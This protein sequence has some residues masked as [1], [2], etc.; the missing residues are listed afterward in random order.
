MRKLGLLMLASLLSFSPASADHLDRYAD[1]F[2][3]TLPRLAEM[4]EVARK[5]IQCTAINI[6]HEARGTSTENQAIVAWV[7]KNRVKS[8]R[9]GSDECETVFQT[10]TR[11]GKTS[12]QFS[13]TIRESRAR[14]EP[15]SWLTAQ[16]I[17]MDVHENKIKDPSDG[18][19][20]LYQKSH[21]RKRP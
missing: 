10:H 7:T 6:Y 9:Y 17:A 21:L 20:D 3:I 4:P 12:A 11:N 1:R 14:F 8:G 18:A 16:R 2:E 5:N 13:W 19:L 15:N